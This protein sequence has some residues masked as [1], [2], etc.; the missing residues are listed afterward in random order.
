MIQQSAWG[1]YQQINTLLQ[2]IAL[3][4]SIGPTYQNPNGLVMKLTHFL[5]DFKHLNG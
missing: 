5:S 4:L 1:T 3:G 2:T